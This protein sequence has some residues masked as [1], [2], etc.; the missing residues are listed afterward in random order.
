MSKRFVEMSNR[1]ISLEII[2][3]SA[4]TQSLLVTVE[5]GPLLTRA[6]TDRVL[7]HLTDVASWEGLSVL[8]WEEW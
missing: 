2:E 8:G 5:S 7:A 4:T 3:T 6:E 1:V